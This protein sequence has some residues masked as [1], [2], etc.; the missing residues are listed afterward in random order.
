MSATEH[1][2]TEYTQIQSDDDMRTNHGMVYSTLS[3]WDLLRWQSHVLTD[4]SARLPHLTLS[5]QVLRSSLANKL[6]YGL[7]E[8][9]ARKKKS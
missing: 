8:S 3:F 9:T 7:R 5:R 1:T 6:V 2:P 4:I